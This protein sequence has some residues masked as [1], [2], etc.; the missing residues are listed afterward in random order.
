MGKFRQFFR[1]K[2]FPNL[3]TLVIIGIT[4]SFSSLAVYKFSQHTP[5]VNR[6]LNN[7]NTQNNTVDKENNSEPADIKGNNQQDQNLNPDTQEKAKILTA[8]LNSSETT[9]LS[10]S[11]TSSGDN[12]DNTISNNISKRNDDDGDDKGSLEDNGNLTSN[13]R[14]RQWEED[15]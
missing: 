11:A 1:T 14:S 15:D 13:S 5:L 8:G 4:V 10:G 7:A 3:I 6:T 2:F 9:N 12:T